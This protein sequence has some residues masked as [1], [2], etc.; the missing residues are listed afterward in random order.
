MEPGTSTNLDTVLGRCTAR[1]ELDK[2][3]Y[4]VSIGIEQTDYQFLQWSK[5]SESMLIFYSFQDLLNE[6]LHEGY[7]WYNYVT[8]D[9]NAILELEK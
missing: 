8:G 9:V 7:F 4:T 2:R 3:G 1:S 5:D 6:P